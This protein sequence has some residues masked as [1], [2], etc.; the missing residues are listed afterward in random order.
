[1]YHSNRGGTYVFR[2]E[3]SEAMPDL[4]EALLLDPRNEQ[5]YVSRGHAFTQAGDYAGAAEDFRR[6]IE[7]NTDYVTYYVSSAY[8][9]GVEDS[10][11]PYTPYDIIRTIR[12]FKIMDG[13]RDAVE[14]WRARQGLPEAMPSSALGKAALKIAVRFAEE[15]IESPEQVYREFDQYVI[16]G[17]DEYAG[18][19]SVA[20]YRE[21]WPMH[22]PDEEIIEGMTA[23]LC[24]QLSDVA[25]EDL[26]FGIFCGYT[27]DSHST[28]RCLHSHRFRDNGW[29]RLRCHA[30][31]QSSRGGWR[32]EAQDKL[33]SDGSMARKYRPLADIPDDDT[34]NA[35]HNPIRLLQLRVESEVFLQRSA[36]PIAQGRSAGGIRSRRDLT[37]HSFTQTRQDGRTGGIG[38]PCRP[39]EYPAAV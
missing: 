20:Y 16:D 8:Y 34:L 12:Q 19:S 6:A 14:S 4:R 7:L 39:S 32:S 15:E 11:R 1:M 5:A 24:R 26:G 2:G 28:L 38:S 37:I 10:V 3:F 31:Q 36:Q 23:V 17:E 27:D 18:W 29:Q 9:D 33:S 21:T 13:V 25:C 30:Y 35:G 22:T